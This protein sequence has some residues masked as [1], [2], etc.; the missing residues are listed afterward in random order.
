MAG[1]NPQREKIDFIIWAVFRKMD[2]QP[3]R[4]IKKAIEDAYP[5][6]E[7]K[8]YPYTIWRQ[9]AAKCWLDYDNMKRQGIPLG[10]DG[11]NEQPHTADQNTNR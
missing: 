3:R 4:E 6:G 7:R 5:Y 1:K 11:H 10:K 8:Y 2:G 9:E